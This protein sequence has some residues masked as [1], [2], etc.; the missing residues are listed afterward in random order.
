MKLIMVLAVPVVLLVA[1]LVSAWIETLKQQHLTV[2]EPVALLVSAW[3]ETL[4]DICKFDFR[5]VALLVS[6]WIETDR[7]A[8]E[9]D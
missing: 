7:Q 9:K 6:A 4:P 1:L 8:E 3:I 5:W 2:L